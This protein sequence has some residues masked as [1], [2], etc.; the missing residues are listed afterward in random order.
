MRTGV[1]A[2]W[3]VPVGSPPLE[4]GWILAEDGIII[5][6]GRGTAPA[7][8]SRMGD[9]MI[10]IP[11]LV[12]AHVHLPL[13]TLRG[14]DDN[15]GF[16]DWIVGPMM[17]SIRRI[18]S[19][20]IHE[21]AD[22]A[23][24]SA[25][26]LLSGGVTMVGENHYRLEGMQA[27]AELGMRGVYFHEVFGSLAPDEIAAWVHTESRLGA[28]PENTGVGRWGISPHSPWTCPTFTF[29][30]AVERA[31][32]ERRRLSF[33]LEESVEERD[34]LLHRRGPLYE[35]VAK[36]G[37]LSRYRLGA[38]PTQV[39]SELGGLGPTTVVAHV[40]QAD[41]EDLRLIAASGTHVVHCPTSNLKLGEGIAPV[42]RMRQLGINVAIGTDSLAS[43][44][45]ADMFE[46]M[47][48]A[49]N[50]ARGVERCANA[51]SATDALA[52]AT[53]NGAE[54][55]GVKHLCGTLE[56]GKWADW[57]VLDIGS[58]AD[59]GLTRIEDAVVFLG[60][61]ER[62]REVVI[63]GMTRRTRSGA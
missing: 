5:D 25:R 62:V 54:A 29:S 27:L 16:H 51:M 2:S 44:S 43:A 39:V 12:S 37:T 61:P 34:F 49:L 17:D 1:A 14:L 18:E 22:G 53:V 4:D 45:R 20:D 23:R 59:R 19:G 57:V 40:V 9:G 46:E 42:S 56:V 32:A 63:A 24:I 33:H 6:M 11:G 21:Y 15:A 55:L 8:C 10:V 13:G 3:I 48:L 36:R 31:R 60:A 30:K 41:E 47:R 26:E 58:R 52:M 7:E 50:L 38:S 28:V 35:S